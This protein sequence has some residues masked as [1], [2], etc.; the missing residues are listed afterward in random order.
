MISISNMQLCLKFSSRLK[1][2]KLDLKV[3]T[4]HLELFEQKNLMADRR[5][6]Y[7][8]QQL[9]ALREIQEEAIPEERKVE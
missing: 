6:K 7:Y 2:V 9:E 1:A 5:Y 3:E 8:E 4:V